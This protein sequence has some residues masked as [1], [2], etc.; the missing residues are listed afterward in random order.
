MRGRLRSRRHTSVGLLDGA[1]GAVGING[2]LPLRC[3]GKK[4]D[5]LRSDSSS[6]VMQWSSVRERIGA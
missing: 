2:R 5:Q 6:G 4:T 3:K 1:E